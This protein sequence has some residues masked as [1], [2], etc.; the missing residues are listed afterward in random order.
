M[1]WSAAVAW[2]SFVKVGPL[3]RGRSLLRPLPRT[4][5]P[6]IPCL[7]LTLLPL[8]FSILIESDLTIFMVLKPVTCLEEERLFSKTQDGVEA[9]ERV[10]SLLSFQSA[11]SNYGTRGVDCHFGSLLP[12]VFGG[13]GRLACVAKCLLLPCRLVFLWGT[14]DYFFVGCFHCCVDDVGKTGRDDVD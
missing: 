14:G 13:L 2:I 8:T 1:T 10:S 11:M 12:H 9:Y 5:P 4:W 7:T 6:H 3:L